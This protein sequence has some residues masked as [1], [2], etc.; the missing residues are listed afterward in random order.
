MLGSTSA[1]NKGPHVYPSENTASRSTSISVAGSVTVPNEYV[2]DSMSGVN[3]VMVRSG[4]CTIQH[5]ATPCSIMKRAL[6]TRSWMPWVG[7]GDLNGEERRLRHLGLVPC[8]INLQIGVD[9]NVGCQFT[10]VE[11]KRKFAE[12]ME[13]GP[14]GRQLK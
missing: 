3:T 13:T 4:G 7:R 12:A 6:F 11:A 2:V 8:E 9:R 5:D 1:V 14:I 10:T